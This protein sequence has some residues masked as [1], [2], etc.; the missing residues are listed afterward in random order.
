MSFLIGVGLSEGEELISG[1]EGGG[2]GVSE[3]LVSSRVKGEGLEG[4]SFPR[5]W[6]WVLEFV[7]EFEEKDRSLPYIL[8]GDVIPNF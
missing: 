4:Q 3:G 8:S 1:E 7:G 5:F 2:T 6:I